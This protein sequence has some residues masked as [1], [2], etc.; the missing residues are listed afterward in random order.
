MLREF[1]RI[2]PVSFGEWSLGVPVKNGS[3]TIVDHHCSCQFSMVCIYIYY[4]YIIY[5][6]YIYI[7]YIYYWLVVWNHGIFYDFPF[8]WEC[9]HPNWRTHI[10]Q[11]GWNHQPDYIPLYQW[12]IGKFIFL[13]INVF[14]NIDAIYGNLVMCFSKKTWNMDEKKVSSCLV[15]R[16][17]C[18][19]A[20]LESALFVLWR[21][22]ASPM[23]FSPVHSKHP[24]ETGHLGIPNFQTKPYINILVY[25][26][27]YN[28]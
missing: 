16:S 27:K 2:A 24:Y 1:L 28:N 19:I 26:L 21:L 18:S 20:R 14:I 10:C 23:N 12:F 5:I 9:H 3:T 7:I 13:C 15:A 17:P 4:I 22:R 11:R 8:S 25:Q 6:L